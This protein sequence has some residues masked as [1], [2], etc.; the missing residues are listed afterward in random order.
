M[1]KLK[2]GILFG[3]SGEEHPVS[4][5]SAREVAKN[6]DPE[7]Y[8]PY[9]IGITQNGAWTLCD[10]PDEGWNGPVPDFLNYTISA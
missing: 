5:K 7:K 1:D 10:G 2:I 6:L 4:V 8:E 3:G 9:F